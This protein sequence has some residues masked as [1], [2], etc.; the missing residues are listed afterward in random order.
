MPFQKLKELIISFLSSSKKLY[1]SKLTANVRN[2]LQIA[3]CFG[4]M[5][6]EYDSPNRTSNI[7]KFWNLPNLIIGGKKINNVDFAVMDADIEPLL[8]MNILNK[9]N[10]YKIDLEKNK[11]Y[12]KNEN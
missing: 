10:I 11:I 9:M 1:A 3:K 12:L 5:K 6:K 2:F 7:Q 8:G 4:A